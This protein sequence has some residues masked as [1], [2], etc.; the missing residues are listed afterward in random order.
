MVD[1]FDLY[2]PNRT[3]AI[4]KFKVATS[5]KY[6]KQAV[7]AEK[8]K[9]VACGSDHGLGYVFDVNLSGIPQRLAHGKGDEL[10]QT[11]EV[12]PLLTLLYVYLHIYSLRLLMVA[13]SLLLDHQE[14]GSIYAFGKGLQLVSSAGPEFLGDQPC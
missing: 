14:E 13:I 2:P 4:K 3:S 10:I 6:I 8:G 5:K 9:L 12:S 7:F 1:G 11:V